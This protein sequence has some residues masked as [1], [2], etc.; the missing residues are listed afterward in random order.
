V[1]RGR[2]FRVANAS[3]LIMNLTANGTLFVLTR[4]LQT[5]LGQSAFTA[6]LMMLPVFAPMAVLAPVAGRVTAR[7]GPRPALLA[8]A[9]FAA[10]G[11]ASL[12]FAEP[13][14]GYQS[15]LPALLLVGLGIGTFTAPVVAA[16]IRSV[17]PDRS[18]LA[19]GI[20][21]TARQAG[22]ALG[23]AVFGAA[24]GSPALTSHFVF[25]LHALGGAA[26]LAWL[27]VIVMMA[28]I[29]LEADGAAGQR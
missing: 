16:A 25:A 18:G 8:G 1:F 6:G 15:V 26:A 20:N 22:T 10:A 23:V 11:M 28:G 3:S 5:V 27:L 29:G 7:Y 19:S 12:V 14:R 17:P 2:A 24:A 13:A 4:Y 9:V 21:N